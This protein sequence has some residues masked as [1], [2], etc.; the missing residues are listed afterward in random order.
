LAVAEVGVET[1][2]LL[3]VEHVKLVPCRPSVLYESTGWK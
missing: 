3:C 1:V 2:R